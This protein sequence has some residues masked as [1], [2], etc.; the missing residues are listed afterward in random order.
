MDILASIKRTASSYPDRVVV[1]TGPEELTYGQL[2]ERSGALASYLLQT[3][4][5]SRDPVPVFGHKSPWMLVCFLACVRAG[6][7]YCPLDISVPEGRLKDI[8]ETLPEGPVFAP[9]PSE[10]VLAGQAAL[11]AG[12]GREIIDTDRLMAV[13]AGQLRKEP[14]EAEKVQ[15]SEPF[16]I[17]F[18]SGSTGRPKGVQITA[19]CLGNFLDWSVTLGGDPQDK[20]GAV[21]LNQAPFSFDLSV[22]DLYTCLAC[23]GTLYCLE[24]TVQSDYRELIAALSASDARVWVSTP[25]FADVCLADHSFSQDLMPELR[26]FL[27]CGETLANKTAKR[28]MT[29]FPD[30]AVIN[31]YGPTESTVA[32]TEVVITPEMAGGTQALPVGRVKPGSFIRIEDEEG[33]MVPEGEKGEIILLGDTV[34]IGYYKDEA[35]TKQAF[36][37]DPDTGMRGY[38]SGDSGYLTDGMLHYCGRLDLQIKLHGYRM[39]LEDIEANLC[40]L[41]NVRQAVVVPGWRQ[42]KVTGLTGYLVLAQGGTGDEATIQELRAALKELLPEY[43]IPRKLSVVDRIPMTPNGKADRKALAGKTV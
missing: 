15:P 11:L 34:S 20:A 39:E 24:K 3:C 28:L 30:A 26:Y 42:G 33:Q 25:S 27:F 22:M 29:R 41:P 12:C 43:M 16:Y 14:D 36:F 6:H 32:L 13:C 5:D 8:L 40:R 7:A 4:K 17:I 10:R 23:G 37:T 19:S 38:H 35:R 21:F 2:W 9:V 1:R 18:T 31:T